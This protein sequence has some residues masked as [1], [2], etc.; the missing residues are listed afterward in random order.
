MSVY[1]AAIVPRLRRSLAGGLSLLLGLCGPLHAAADAG[2]SQLREQLLLHP[3]LQVSDAGALRFR[4]DAEGAMGLPNP[5]VTL[6]LNNLPISDPVRFDRYLPSSKSLEVM[7]RIPSLSGRE[8]QRET[9][10]AMAG[11][12]ELER[13]R[14]LA[15]LEQRLITALVERQRIAE[16]LAALEEQLTLLAELERWLRGEMAGGGAVYGRFDELDVQRAR[17]RE[18]QVALRG[19]DRRQQAE[20][21]ALVEAVPD[22][23]PPKI[24]P[25]AWNGE[26]E[27][28]IPVRIAVRKAAI[29]RAQVEEKRAAFEPDFSIAA[30]YQQRESGPNFDGDDRFTLKATVSLPLWAKSNQKPKLAAAEA[31]LTAALAE[32]QRVLR[33]A[34]FELENA[35]ADHRTADELLAA[36]AQRAA[37]LAGLEAANRRRYQAGESSLENVIRPAQQRVEVTME[38]AEQRAR[39]IIAAARV[40]A[41]LVEDPR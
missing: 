9:L 8:A 3:S 16:T 5:S 37:M 25:H 30:A 11:L 1:L 22:T 12:A 2:Y 17:I 41:L 31:A 14:D 13:R 20:L 19:E 34:H 7:Q 35:L 10:L 4:R 21:Q 28:L 36:L 40:N 18:R 29:V 15:Q 23:P 24:Q 26:P 27:T 39:R 33:E 38:E 32:Q 6:G